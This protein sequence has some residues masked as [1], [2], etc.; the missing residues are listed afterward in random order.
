MVDTT[1]QRALALNREGR[2]NRAIRHNAK[3][4][5]HPIHTHEDSEAILNHAIHVIR[6]ANGSSVPTRVSKQSESAQCMREFQTGNKGGI[7][8][9]TPTG[10]KVK[11]SGRSACS[12]QTRNEELMRGAIDSVNVDDMTAT[13][14]RDASGDIRTIAEVDHT[15][16]KDRGY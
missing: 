6:V 1:V 16:E 9:W 2:R 12:G 3:R 7:L 4:H 10:V 13:S 8:K 11:T 5:V 14:L 15:K